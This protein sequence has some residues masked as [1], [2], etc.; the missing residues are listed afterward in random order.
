MLPLL[1]LKGAALKA[2]MG[3]EAAKATTAKVEMITREVEKGASVLA[4]MGTGTQA[5]GAPS[6]TLAPPQNPGLLYLHRRNPK[7]F[8]KRF[9]KVRFE[10]D[11][12]T[13]YLWVRVVTGARRFVG[14]LATK[15][16]LLHGATIG[17]AVTFLFKD[18]VDVQDD[19]AIRAKKK[20]AAKSKRRSRGSRGSRRHRR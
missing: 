8:E 1:A 9:V 14:L 4:R 11:E 10:G 19:R 6:S 5:N 13:E 17:D 20:H 18:V 3:L 15:P 2:M 7:W 16:V 12:G